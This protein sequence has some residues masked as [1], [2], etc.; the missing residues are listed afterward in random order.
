MK[1]FQPWSRIFLRHP[2]TVNLGSK[3]FKTEALSLNAD[4]KPK[5][6]LRFDTFPGRFAKA[7]NVYFLLS[8]CI[9][10][11]SWAFDQRAWLFQG[12]WRNIYGIT[13]WMINYQGGFLRRGLPGEVLLFFG[14]QTG[15]DIGWTVV[16]FC[17]LLYGTYILIMARSSRGYL[18]AWAI[19]SAP[20]LGYPVYSGD[21]IRKDVLL[22]LL[23]IALLRSIT[24]LRH[25]LLRQASIGVISSLA[26]LSHELFFF[27]GLPVSLVADAMLCFNNFKEKK[28]AD[29][30]LY[31]ATGWAPAVATSFLVFWFKGNASQAFAILDSWSSLN[32][33][34]KQIENRLPGALSWLAKSS[35]DAIEVTHSLLLTTHFGFPL[36][37]FVV[38]AAALAAL[39]ITAL[40]KSAH[41]S[42]NFAFFFLIQATLMSPVYFSALDQGRWI[43]VTI[44]SALIYSLAFDQ[45]CLAHSFL[46]IQRWAR[47]VR[48]SIS[49]VTS[50]VALSIWGFPYIGWSLTGWL[51]GTPLAALPTRAYFYM[52]SSG[53]IPKLF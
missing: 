2:F 20:L 19:W 26:L 13:E 1:R 45:F 52:R 49:P 39:V 7:L 18:P 8:L 22:L 40:C 16:I 30:L 24:R 17:L 53:V 44:N 29:K 10:F 33:A 3:A 37:L 42:Q 23:L 32:P 11:L 5:R 36:W 9:G 41:K 38:S 21:I 4:K 35:E 34:G 12:D 51:Y 6:F 25:G 48:T 31:W 46:G 14:R 28:L 27:F 47:L 50:L 15:F 43:F